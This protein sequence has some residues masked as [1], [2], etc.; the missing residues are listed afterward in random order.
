MVSLSVQV[1]CLSMSVR[2]GE[3]VS[4]FLMVTSSNFKQRHTKTKLSQS[5]FVS[6]L[7]EIIE[8]K[9]EIFTL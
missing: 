7:L 4:L 3:K 2:S 9:T 5:I 1:H 8:F 6:C